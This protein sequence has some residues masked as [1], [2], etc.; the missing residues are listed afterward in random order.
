MRT[1]AGSPLTALLLLIGTVACG[2]GSAREATGAF[3]KLAAPGPTVPTPSPG[4]QSDWCLQLFEPLAPATTKAGETVAVLQETMI[5]SARQTQPEPVSV[6]LA[7]CRSDQLVRDGDRCQRTVSCEVGAGADARRVA[8]S[9]DTDLAALAA[10]EAEARRKTPREAFPAICVPAGSVA[11]GEATWCVAHW[12]TPVTGMESAPSRYQL[13]QFAIRAGAQVLEL[14]RD[15]YR[16]DFREGNPTNCAA[17]APTTVAAWPDGQ[18]LPGHAVLDVM[19]AGRTLYL[20]QN[21]NPSLTCTTLGTTSDGASC[22]V[23]L[24]C[25]GDA[26]VKKFSLQLPLSLSGEP[27]ALPGEHCG[28]ASSHKPHGCWVGARLSRVT[29]GASRW[30]VVTR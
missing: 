7:T 19:Q 11:G 4:P 10:L 30:D 15:A 24:L 3:P 12:S 29:S 16:D 22:E 8:F 5:L 20:Q 21:D 9:I 6:G 17:R 23:G 28:P 2:G 13:V 14:V 18:P 27:G 1:T 25:S 26:S